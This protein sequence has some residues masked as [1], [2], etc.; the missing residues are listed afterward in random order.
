MSDEDED[1]VIQVSETVSTDVTSVTLTLSSS[2]TDVTVS[3]ATNNYIYDIR[4][5]DSDGEPKVLLAGKFT[6]KN[7]VTKSTS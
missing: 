4:M 2:D 1:A 6:V 3:S 5:I 7:P